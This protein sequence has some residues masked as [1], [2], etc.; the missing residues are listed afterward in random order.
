MS[1]QECMCLCH[2]KSL[3]RH[4]DNCEYGDFLPTLEHE[5]D[6]ILH[7]EI[8]DAGTKVYKLIDLNEAKQTLLSL[9]KAEKAKSE[10]KG[11]D[12]AHKIVMDSFKDI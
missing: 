5:L 12:K 11:F 6:E 7:L 2:G 1:K 10:L 3:D 8:T 9:I 4:C